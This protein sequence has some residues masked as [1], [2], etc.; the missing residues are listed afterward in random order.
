MLAEILPTR[1]LI[2]LVSAVASQML[3]LLGV[4]GLESAPTDPPAWVRGPKS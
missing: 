1:L 3:F 2:V 4:M